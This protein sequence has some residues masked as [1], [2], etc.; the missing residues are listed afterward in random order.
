MRL[1]KPPI[2]TALLW[3]YFHLLD[4]ETMARTDLQTVRDS[5]LY[6]CGWG[7]SLLY[8]GSDRL[9][10]NPLVFPVHLPQVHAGLA[11]YPSPHQKKTKK[12]TASKTGKQN[13]IRHLEINRLRIK[14]KCA[15]RG[16]LFGA[17]FLPPSTLCGFR[18][19]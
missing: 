4:S 1:T 11:G 15:L 12:K 5:Y 19:F 9:Q 7:L 18:F 10:I 6:P 8:A 2:Y 3:I 17:R 16:A 14:D 13:Q